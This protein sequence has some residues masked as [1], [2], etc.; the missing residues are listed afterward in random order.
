MN[1]TKIASST[2]I[3]ETDDTKIL[4]D[5]WI[6]NGE[7]YGSWSIVQQ[8]LD[9]DELYKQMNE[10]ENIYFSHIH[11]DHFSK[12]TLKKINKNK[13][14]FI[15][16]YFSPFLKKNLEAMGFNNINEIENGQSLNIKGETNIT[17]FAADNCNPNICNKFVGCN[18]SDNSK[19]SQ[20]IDSCAVINDKSSVCVNL[21]DCMQPMMIETVRKIKHKFKK[22]SILLVNYNSAHSY[23]Q[24]IKNIS[25]N[26]KIN[27]GNDLKRTNLEKT[28]K[29]IDDLNPDFFIPFA[30]EYTLSGK[31]F[32]LD[33]FKGTNS[34]NECYDFFIDSKYKKNFVMLNY[35]KNFD[36]NKIPNF[37]RINKS[38]IS[39]Y[40]QKISNLPYDYELIEKP[41][42]SE[43]EDLSNLALKNIMNKI[44][45]FKLK[46]NHVLYIQYFNKFIY[47]D[48]DNNSL[49]FVNGILS[50]TRNYTIMHLDEKLLLQLLKGPRFSH[51]NNADIGSHIDYTKSKVKDYDYKLFNCM[52]YFHS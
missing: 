25:D 23:P 18:Y 39:E 48:F 26:E 40:N 51:W 31:K 45:L 41:T 28:I 49:K 5:P 46:F 8:L 38:D 32:L 44:N 3:I 50:D 35:G 19:N 33:C 34:Q 9:K 11:P 37:E 52:A 43:I 30:G 15:H 16:K 20:Q 42:K 22:I 17:I 13:K 47:L 2:V 4:C 10:C 6:E 24:N 27:I 12:K 7:Y 14:V 21:N 36:G 29:Y 1:I